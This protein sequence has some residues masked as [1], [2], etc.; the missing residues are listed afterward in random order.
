M[1]SD[2]LKKFFT[3]YKEY[4]VA[5][6]HT[7]NVADQYCSYLRKACILSDLGVG[8]IEAIAAIADANVQAALCEYLMA[9]LSNAFETTV[10]KLQKKK[11]SDYKSA[12][13]ALSGFITQENNE[14]A[15]ALSLLPAVELPFETTED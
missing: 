2:V 7:R 8:F 14:K 1:K 4:L 3:E 12:V 10:D 6:E 15:E 13:S 11:I 5:T 9:K